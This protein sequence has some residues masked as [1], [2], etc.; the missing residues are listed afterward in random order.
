MRR[1]DRE[2]KPLF[3]VEKDGYPRTSSLFALA[4]AHEIP[5]G[6]NGFGDKKPLCGVELPLPVVRPGLDHPPPAG[7][8]EGDRERDMGGD[9]EFTGV[10]GRRVKGARAQLPVKRPDQ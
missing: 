3:L 4:A 10:S 1:F 7:W 8:G 2:K 5:L 6:P 9:F